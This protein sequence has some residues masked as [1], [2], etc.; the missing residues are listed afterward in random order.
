MTKNGMILMFLLFLAGCGS[1]TLD[2]AS[3][4]AFKS[5]VSSLIKDVSAKDKAHLRK[6]FAIIIQ[7][8]KSKA[9]D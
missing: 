6:S 8:G 4:V 1:V 9:W 2:T 5:S 7:M 3:E